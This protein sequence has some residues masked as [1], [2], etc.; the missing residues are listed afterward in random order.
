M[1]KLRQLSG[2]T[3]FVLLLLSGFCIFLMLVRLVVSGNFMHLYLPWNLLLAWIPAGFAAAY[4]KSVE[5]KHPYLL[6]LFFLLSWLAFLPNAPYILTDMVHLQ[7]RGDVPFWFDWLLLISFAWA[8]FLVGC[9]SLAEVWRTM[10]GRWHE[11]LHLP[12]LLFV[13]LATAFGVYLGRFERWNSWDLLLHPGGVISDT[14]R[15]MLRPHVIAMTGLFSLFLILA[16]GSIRAVMN[17]I[18]E[19]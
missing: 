11:R 16:W 14:F 18:R 15:A 4:R 3:L 2:K 19:E 12:F 7:P 17:H 10:R 5:A 6:R 9:W 1:E 13:V 8:G